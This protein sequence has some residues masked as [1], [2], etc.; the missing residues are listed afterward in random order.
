[1]LIVTEFDDI[2]NNIS[3]LLTYRELSDFCA[4]NKQYKSIENNL[5]YNFLDAKRLY[6]AL[7]VW[8]S[9]SQTRPRVNSW[10][11]K[12]WDPSEKFLF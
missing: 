1:M 12:V 6:N 3:S 7:L 5:E 4:V 2:L 10:C 9:H 8:K 11:R